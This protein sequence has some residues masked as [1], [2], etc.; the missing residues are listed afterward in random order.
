MSNTATFVLGLGSGLALWQLTRG[1]C[2]SKA[3]GDL[4]AP[5]APNDPSTMTTT[6]TTATQ[7]ASAPLAQ[8]LRNGLVRLDASGL[9]LDGA[10]VDVDDAVARCHAAGRAAVIAS[11]DASASL[12][13]ELMTALTAA[14][15]PI[16]RNA[17]RH[18]TEADATTLFTLITYPRGSR[19]PAKH[20]SFRAE[21]P[22]A[23][24]EARDRLAAAGLLDLALAGRTH[25]QGGWMLSISAKDFR[26]HQAE[27]LPGAPRATD[28]RNA[29]TSTTF[30]LATYTRGV[31]GGRRTVRWFV[32]D[33]PT[34]WEDAR[35]RLAAGGLLD[36]GMTS[37][38]GPGYWKLTTEP[39]VFRLDRAKPLPPLPV[40]RRGAR[41]PAARYTRDG[42]RIF[43]DGQP[44]VVVERVGSD[45]DGY[46]IS[47]HDADRLAERIVR[48][49][50]RHGA[51]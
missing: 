13:A 6:N 20:R 49:L 22:I 24:T 7:L 27:A 42:R 1:P 31:G 46:A 34:T 50:D 12:Y 43:R 18:K 35:D 2:S 10:A 14:R 28:V 45:R 47:P 23:W 51:R 29:E 38:N 25:Q 39:S 19:Q 17:T 21:A 40:P 16:L 5:N 9:T 26:A 30:T 48:L 8:G 32:S 11:P 37:P 4:I 36:R 41:R 3:L 44:I 33:M 15:V